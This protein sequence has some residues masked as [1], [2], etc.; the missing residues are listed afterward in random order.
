MRFKIFDVQFLFS[1][2]LLTKEKMW[3]TLIVFWA[4]CWRG[5]L[6]GVVFGVVLVGYFFLLNLSD[7]PMDESF[8]LEAGEGGALLGAIPVFVLFILAAFYISYYTLFHKE[9]P[10]FERDFFKD[11][12]KKFFSWLFWKPSLLTILVGIIIELLSM[13][14]VW[15]LHPFVAFFV[16]LAISFFLMHFYLHGGTWGFVPVPRDNGEK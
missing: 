14:F 16:K 15:A 9:Y 5:M 4:Q 10:A 3:Q 12:P 11:K 1:L 6:L 13:L 8:M 7:V 2:A